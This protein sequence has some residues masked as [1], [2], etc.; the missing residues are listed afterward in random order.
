[1]ADDDPRSDRDLVER[2]AERLPSGGTV[3]GNA[4][5]Q[6]VE[7][8]E[9]LHLQGREWDAAEIAAALSITRVREVSREELADTG[10]PGS[11]VIAVLLGSDLD[12]RM[13]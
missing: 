4:P 10:A 12:P 13:R 7:R 5:R 9:V 11:A 1:M 2:R 3:V 6:D 8:S